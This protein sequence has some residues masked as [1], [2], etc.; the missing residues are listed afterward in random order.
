MAHLFGVLRRLAAIYVRMTEDELVAYTVADVGYVKVARLATHL[1][2]ENH[3]Q[4]HIAQ[5]L[6]YLLHVMLGD[7]V[8][9]LEGLLYRVLTQTIEGLFPVPRT[10]LTQFIHDGKQTVESC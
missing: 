6:A 5:L 3:V 10:A 7:G 9:Q 2:V 1:R 8:G 4:Q